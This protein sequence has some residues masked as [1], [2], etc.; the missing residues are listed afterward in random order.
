[1]MLFQSAY[2]RIALTILIA[3][4][5]ITIAFGAETSKGAPADSTVEVL[6]LPPYDEVA[7]AG[8]SPNTRKFIESILTGKRQLTVIPFPFRDLMDV[9]HQMV[10]DKQY[11]RS[12]LKKV[13]CDIIIM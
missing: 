13:D 2:M 7:S 4:S 5:S 3:L 6:V 8:N 11:C 9:P 10:F 12:I 1:M